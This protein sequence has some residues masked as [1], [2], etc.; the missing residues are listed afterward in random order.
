MY[1]KA[2]K[3]VKIPSTTALKGILNFFFHVCPGPESPW[4]CEI[5]KAFQLFSHLTYTFGGASMS[6]AV[7]S[8]ILV[9]THDDNRPH[10]SAVVSSLRSCGL[11]PSE[12][13][14]G[15][16]SPPWDEDDGL[17]DSACVVYVGA[18]YEVRAKVRVLEEHEVAQVGY[19][20][21][22]QSI[23]V[24]FPGQILIAFCILVIKMLAQ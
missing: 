22:L 19:K 3:I 10:N 15:E 2:G 14:P 20:G 11:A 17:R 7:G 12:R 18:E 16:G 5:F 24:E 4:T 1:L 6:Q 13:L 23:M 9:V 8:R 21:K